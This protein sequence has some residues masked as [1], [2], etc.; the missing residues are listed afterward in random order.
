MGNTVSLRVVRDAGGQGESC[1]LHPEPGLKAREES[2]GVAWQGSGDHAGFF[3][4]SAGSP[5][6]AGW[7]LLDFSL[8]C[9]EGHVV[10][11]ELRM[12]FATGE[13]AEHNAFSLPEPDAQGHV[14]ALVLFKFPVQSLHLCPTFWAARFRI[15][16]VRLTRLTRR[17]A[18]WRMLAGVKMWRRTLRYVRDVLDGGLKS[19]TDRVFADYLL[20]TK[21]QGLDEYDVWV[22]KYDTFTPS[23][24]DDLQRRVDG[25]APVGETISVLLRVERASAGDAVACVEKVLGQ[26]WPRWEMHVV[27]DAAA[28]GELDDLRRIA[29]SDARVH[30]LEAQGATADACNSVLQQ[31]R[32]GYVAIID[33]ACHPR[34]HAFLEV[35]ERLRDQP[36]LQWLYGDEDRMHADGHR[37]RPVFKP[38][39][40]PDLLESCNYVGR[41]SVMQAELARQAG[42]FREG[43]ADPWH[44]LF[45]RC[46]E[47]V[48]PDGIAHLPHILWHDVSPDTER[49][50]A[51]GD[52]DGATAI[53]AHL[54]RM[55]ADPDLQVHPQSQGGYRVQWP[56]PQTAPRISLIIPTRDRVALLRACVESIFQ[57][58]TWTDYEIVV[59]DNGTAEP[60]A[61]AYLEHLRQDARVRVLRYDREFNYPAINN[62]AVA[63]CDSELVCLLNNDVEVITPGWMQEMAGHAMRPG[64]GAVGA[65]LYYPDDTI[66]HAGVIVG[67][68]GVADHAYAGQ[69]RGVAGHGGRARV[70]QNLSAVTA[71]CLMVRRQTYLQAGGLDERL[72]VAFN[73]VDFCLRLGALGYRN[74]W[75]PHA[76]LYHHESA[77]RGSDHTP[78]RKARYEGE[79]RRMRERWPE[80][81]AADPAFNPNLSLDAPDFRP[82][83]PPRGR[84]R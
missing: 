40:N 45:L 67:M 6:P 42:G 21:P 58:S 10:L 2:G 27:V 46:S 13:A 33:A 20:R 70:V 79:I 63:Q 4:R 71:A 31:I 68:H 65:M 49:S 81:I 8:I 84:A 11:P 28:A 43:L 76:E 35:A 55:G 17:G 25:L 5:W 29:V 41:F 59:V 73:D 12:R 14:R 80:M 48:R 54:L 32:H 26:A 36:G 44:D 51:A 60:R 39:W 72:A 74:V 83:F 52:A 34:R 77:S 61:L 3:T 66:Q 75:T 7:Y 18:L 62:F 64:V 57:R 30:L 19:A 38:D 82:A 47:H 69:P 9:I 15:G 53:R 23:R 16:Q 22:R 24:C 56:L 50:P 78:E 1:E 37:S